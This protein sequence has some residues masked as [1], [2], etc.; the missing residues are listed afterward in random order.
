LDVKKIVALSTLSQLGL[1]FL[2]IYRSTKFIIL[3]HLIIHA[4]AKACLFTIIG[5]LIHQRFSQQDSRLIRR[6]LIGSSQ[7]LAA[8]ICVIRLRGVL[9]TSGFFSKEMILLNQNSLLRRVLRVILY[10]F[11]ISLTVAYC[12][13]LM[14]V[15]IIYRGVTPNRKEK[16]MFLLLPGVVLRSLS[17]FLGICFFVN[18]FL[19]KMLI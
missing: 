4:F 15:V 7:R 13:K 17:I 19:V 16:R 6:G 14:L 9:F 5:G 12:I 11:V 10:A 18:V 8:I 1:I 2:G 3:F